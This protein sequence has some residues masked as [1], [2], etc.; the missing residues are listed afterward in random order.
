MRREE[1]AALAG[2]SLAWYTRLEQGRD[3]QLSPSAL[4]RIADALK[5]DSGERR[6]LQHLAGS[7][8]RA[9]EAGEDRQLP[10]FHAIIADHPWPAYIKDS[11]WNVLGWNRPAAMLFGDYGRLPPERRNILWLVYRTQFYRDLLPDWER[12]AADVTARFRADMVRYPVQ[13]PSLVER[14]LVESPD[15]SA[16]W[17]AHAIMTE[18]SGIKRLAHPNAGV[19]RFVHVRLRSDAPD[20][21]HLVVTQYAPADEHSRGAASALFAEPRSLVVPIPL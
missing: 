10:S 8:P 13:Q 20:S 6:H 16:H 15:F 1:V 18:G 7:V 17:T 9:D 12:D 21:A 3:I 19:M 4:Q 14:L 11:E 2:L 5:L